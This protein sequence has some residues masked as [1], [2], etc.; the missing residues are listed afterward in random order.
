MI[1]RYE[2]KY[3]VPESMA[4]AIR[5]AALTVG[6]KDPY[7]GRDGHYPIRS[8]YLDTRQF[9]LYHANER[10]APDR[11]KARV[12]CYPDAPSAPV[13]LEIKRRVRVVIQKSRGAVPRAQ[14]LTT[15][16]GEPGALASVKPGA[17]KPVEAFVRNALLYHLEP[18]ILVEYDREAFMSDIDEYARLTIDRGVR[19]QTVNG[20]ALEADPKGWRRIDSAVR[21]QTVDPR[22]VLEL[23]FQTR[24]PRWMVDLV[25]RL[26]LIRL[27]FSKYCYGIEAANQI[28][29][30]RVPT[31]STDQVSRAPALVPKTA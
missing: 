3:L 8:L 23:K 11:F 31:Y 22:A 13:F 28:P 1:E 4:P 20:W 2:F 26:D 7:A 24:P 16:Q 10:Q 19:C 9:H 21:T 17:R 5:A 30:S 25:R 29:A 27:S 18:A 15:A 12:R 6:R 14:W